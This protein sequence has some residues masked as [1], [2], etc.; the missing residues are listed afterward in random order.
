MKQYIKQLIAV[1]LASL[2][3]AMP[4]F[5]RASAVVAATEPT[6]IMNNIQ[7]M[8]SYIEQYETDINTIN[9]LTTQIE[10][11]K[12]Q[13]QNLQKLDPQQWLRLMQSF[14]NLAQM[15]Q[16]ILGY[17]WTLEN[18]DTAYEQRFPT[19]AEM[20]Q[21]NYGS[22]DY[23]T[24]QYTDWRDQTDSDLKE[25]FKYYM[26]MGDDDKL[27]K[28]EDALDQLAAASDN[29]TGQMQAIQTGNQIAVAMARHILELKTITNQ[30]AQTALKEQQQRLQ[31]EKANDARTSAVYDASAPTDKPNA[32][33]H[34]INW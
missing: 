1:V 17:S 10:S 26:K 11:L 12:V 6:Q 2:F 7:L 25:T 8:L 16:K 4:P 20:Q 18:F 21:Q 29:A 15:R 32:K 23:F 19:Y 22:A 13:Y 5:A 27:Q 33:Y 30:Q 31:N 3:A 9:Q 14:L 24:K 34:S 28:D